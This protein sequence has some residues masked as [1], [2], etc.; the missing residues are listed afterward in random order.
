M[1]PASLAPT[2][3]PDARAREHL[4][5]V[6]QQLEAVFMRQLFAAMRAGGDK[7]GLFGESTS[8]EMFTAMLDDHLAETAAQKMERGLGE[9]I[10]RQLSRQ[11][12]L[13]E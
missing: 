12:N 3:N 10:Y 11:L 6:C 9:A 13:E 1:K 7:E 4:R 5:Q 8:E 2:P